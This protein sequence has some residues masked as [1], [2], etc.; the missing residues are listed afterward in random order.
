MKA[1]KILLIVIVV[2]VVVVVG[3]AAVFLSTF[4]P[5]DHKDAIAAKVQEATG[6][7][8]SLEGPIE[9]AFWPKIRLKAGPLA[10]GNAP[11]FGDEPMFAA[12][13]IQVAVATLPLLSRRLEMDT[14][15]LHG[16]RVN[17]A[18]NADGI[19]NFDDLA[20]GGGE[21]SG[22][23]DGLAAIV[24]GGVDIKDAALTWRD[25]TSGQDVTI[26]KLNAHTGALTF[27]EPVDFELALTAV[28]N[29]PALDS[30]V[31]LSGTVSYDLDDEHYVIT[32][33]ALNTVLRGNHLPGGMAT[34][35]FGAKVDI[36]RGAGT[37][38]ISDISLN[39]LGTALS[40]GFE[41]RDIEAERP[42]ASGRLELT[43]E[44]LAAIFNAF[45]LPVGKQLGGVAERGF[46]FKTA[47][48]AD[49]DTGEVV[50]SELDGK[51]L[52]ATLGGSFKASRANTDKPAA[53]GQLSASG[54]DLPTLLAVLGQLQGADAATLKSLRE[55]LA[56]A[57]DKSFAINADL[58]ADLGA[59]RADLPRL[60]AKLLGNT[61]AG[62]VHAT[63]ADTDKP[64]IKAS[65]TAQGP[66]FPTLATV[67]AQFQGAD[68]EAIKSLN[69][70][71]GS[72]ADKSFTVKADVDADLAKGTAVVPALDAKLLG[73][74]V[75]GNVSASGI[76]GDKPAAKGKLEARGADLPALLAIASQFQADGAGL[77]DLAAGLA[78]EKD[79]AFALAAGFDTDL[80]SG[81]LEVPTLSAQL[82]G[83]DVKGALKGDG[84]DFEKGRGQLDGKLGVTSADL[85]TLLRS[86][87][88][89]DL[90][91]SLRTLNL[92]L[93]VKG[94]L[95]DLTF[96]P[97]TVTTQ[98]VSPEVGKPVDLKITSGSARA[99][100]DQ[101]TLTVKDL[102]VTG[103]G[104]NA[105][106][107]LDVVNLSKE[108]SYTGSLDVPVFNL[109]NLLASLNKP[110]PK[111]ADPKALTRIGLNSQLAG[112]A[113][114]A[115]LDKLAITLDDTKI[116][117]NVDVADFAGPDLRFGIGIDNLDADRY[118][119]P[120]PPGQ[121][122]P[123]T[124]EAA[125]AGAASE[126]PV[127]T[128]R[129]LKIKGDLLIG[130]L[131]LSGAKLSNVKFSINADGGDIKLAPLAAELYQ[132]RY[133][134]VINLNAKGAQPLLGL[135]TKL[136]NVNVEPL[137]VDTVQNNSL[138]GQ[139]SFDAA[140]NATGGDAD[141]MKKSLSGQ[142]RFNTVNGVFRG[143]D[144]VAVLRAV[145]QIIE[146]KCPVPVPKGGETRFTSLGGTLNANNGVIHNQDLVL[147]GDGFKITGK[148]MLANLHDMS[149]KYDL[150]LAVDETRQTT[151]TA[152]YNLGGYAVP[153]A[154]RGSIESPSCLPDVGDI[155]KQVVQS[156]AKKKVQDAIGDKLEK[157]IPG[158]AGEALKK[159]FKF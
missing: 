130:Q 46:H 82:M 57:A 151:G 79:R 148:G 60:D 137:L 37:A 13:D 72:A 120:T 140:L 143:V 5:N 99:N 25:A 8:L 81:R 125:A 14:V 106:A 141:R 17:L 21:E 53:T 147:A 22:G 97:F 11:G 70:A 78:K 42:S 40:G 56:R 158:D 6:R 3:G 103:L 109:R 145:E 67:I 32:P 138:S 157:V 124:P 91:K 146:C 64:A 16:I 92:D 19:S 149:V 50:V 122:R 43:G 66:D 98:V 100:L 65:L 20:G 139:V 131:K 96:A 132:G 86:A 104:L 44:D 128:L 29:Q 55:A 2:A 84:V 113:K 156:A 61:I 112:T 30:D 63:H 119:E 116:Q 12:D 117:G 76:D 36:N 33:L 23:G 1:I 133:D 95:S 68:G 108:M 110:V 152:N 136:A 27:G 18:R 105:R 58:D 71:L 77:R 89:A 142:G 35:D 155:L 31:K 15:V 75:T 4:D 47:F 121:A 111:T 45:Q 54:P 10:L 80:G 26:S 150:Q 127:E 59:G 102:A 28:A 101:D 153:I 159:L 62:E 49:M 154:C 34:V 74:S 94:S 85:G 107:N 9:M 38:S 135:N 73:N 90:A 88:Q 7:T 114:S 115:K 93:G 41:A 83:L 129:A 52:G 48:D 144:A 126:L 51:L 24:L 87:G 69:A 39:G 118:L 134:G 123:V